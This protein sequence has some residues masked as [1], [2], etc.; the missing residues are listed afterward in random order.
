M[1]FL[2]P[3]PVKSYRCRPNSNLTFCGSVKHKDE[4]DYQELRNFLSYTD[5]S[6]GQYLVDAYR[7]LDQLSFTKKKATPYH[8]AR[9]RN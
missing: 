4:L 2:P 1:S 7:E 5:T 6:I 3:K 9:S 8:F